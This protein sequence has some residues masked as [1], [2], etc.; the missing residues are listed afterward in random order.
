MSSDIASQW[1][2]EFRANGAPCRNPSQVV[3]S[4]ACPLFSEDYVA[5]QREEW[6]RR[7]GIDPKRL[8]EPPTPA[9]LFALAS[10]WGTPE[11]RFK[12][13][14][15]MAG[16]TD[17]GLDSRPGTPA[18]I[19]RYEHGK[20][21]ADATVV[22]LLAD[23]LKIN[24]RIITDGYN[25]LTLFGDANQGLPFI[26]P[27]WRATWE[28]RCFV[29]AVMHAYMDRYPAPERPA[30]PVAIIDLWRQLGRPNLFT[31]Q[32][33]WADKGSYLSWFDLAGVEA[34]AHLYDGQ[35]RQLD[36]VS[37]RTIRA[38]LTAHIGNHDFQPGE[39]LYVQREGRFIAVARLPTFCESSRA[40]FQLG[41][42]P[43]AP[44]QVPTRKPKKNKAKQDVG[45]Q[46]KAEAGQT[47]R[48]GQVPVVPLSSVDFSE[49]P[50]Q[51]QADWD[52]IC[53]TYRQLTRAASSATDAPQST[54]PVDPAPA[55][56]EPEQK[57]TD[58]P[59][60]TP[61]KPRRKR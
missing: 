54:Q 4:A 48:G 56:A 28:A 9:D 8:V 47:N 38:I 37:E 32:E 20:S 17:T 23:K 49:P 30:H 13:L 12:A 6:Q 50:Q 10:G 39:P 51:C 1:I 42:E 59:R 53:R 52:R 11:R 19:S 26:I 16:L 2:D 15:L 43:A 3:P 46:S 25:D 34:V 22:K 57:T 55:S 61:S 41:L 18:A 58:L 5:W 40:A 31:R 60:T 24:L 21:N 7:L 36:L 33:W 14:R 29:D 44:A 27:W 35:V 45:K